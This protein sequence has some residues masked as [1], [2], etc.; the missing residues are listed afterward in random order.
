M[1]HG[2][3]KGVSNAQHT[4]KTNSTQEELVINRSLVADESE[5]RNNAAWRSRMLSDFLN[6]VG[7]TL[8]ELKG[9]EGAEY[10][11]HVNEPIVEP[12][13]NDE[14]LCEQ[15]LIKFSATIPGRKEVN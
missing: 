10:P 13:D 11:L 4:Q 1:K 9:D 15:V 6:E 3:G 12:F 5:V 14:S 8:Y 2:N 7:A